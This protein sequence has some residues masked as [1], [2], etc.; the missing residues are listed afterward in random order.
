MHADLGI[1][2]AFHYGIVTALILICVDCFSLFANSP[3][4]EPQRLYMDLDIAIGEYVNDRKTRPSDIDDAIALIHAVRSRNLLIAGITTVFGNTNIEGVNRALEKTLKALDA[5]GI[6][7]QSGAVGP[8]TDTVSCPAGA[9]QAAKFLAR[10]LRQYQG[11]IVSLGPL[12]NVACLI[13]QYPEVKKNIKGIFAVMAQGPNTE[14]MINDV[15]L[16]DFNF[17]QD[18]WAAKRIIAENIPTY[19]FPFEL[20]KDLVIPKIHFAKS[21]KPATKIGNLLLS[22]KNF[23]NFWT[24]NFKENGIHPWDS[25][26]IVFLEKPGLFSCQH[27]IFE[28]ANQEGKKKLLAKPDL[29]KKSSHFF[30]NTFKNEAAKNESLADIL[31]FITEK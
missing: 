21:K 14:L 22:G 25:A 5:E 29:K 3:A 20:T 15:K 23:I 4:R 31:G 28:I 10:G 6:E 1:A 19:F 9:Q 7:H 16:R 11:Q 18:P 2:A 26:P 24:D 17:S 8:S 30:C 27:S 12:T 13:A